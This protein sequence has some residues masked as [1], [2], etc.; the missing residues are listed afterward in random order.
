MI[1]S[2]YGSKQGGNNRGQVY[3]LKNY[4]V[5]YKHSDVILS[6]INVHIPYSLKEIVVVVVVVRSNSNGGVEV[7]S[8]K[9]LYS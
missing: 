2:F 9:G 3:C 1:G 7:N 5:T 8:V 4:I 6:L